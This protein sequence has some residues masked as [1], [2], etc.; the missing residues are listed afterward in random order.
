MA[1]PN[2]TH[3][4]AWA[5]QETFEAEGG[6][7][8]GPLFQW[9]AFKSLNE[10]QESFLAGDKSS[11]LE[12]IDLCA[13][14]DVTMPPWLTSA[15][16]NLYAG[17]MKGATGSWDETF[18]GRPAKGRHLKREHSNLINQYR[19]KKAIEQARER[20]EAMNNEL[21]DRIGREL[22]VGGASTVKKLNALARK[23]R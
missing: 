14:Y 3:D 1:D 20:G 5:A 11:V 2:W 12:A 17:A 8:G 19:V 15:F 18:G 4:E 23:G 6:R 9:L 22:G 16:R 13:T 10:L 21:F 7:R